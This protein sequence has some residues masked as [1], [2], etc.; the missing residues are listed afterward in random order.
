MENE[1]NIHQFV[2]IDSSEL[3]SRKG[4]IHRTRRILLLL[5][6]IMLVSMNELI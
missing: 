5:L 1:V 6:G 4:D 3:L 2:V